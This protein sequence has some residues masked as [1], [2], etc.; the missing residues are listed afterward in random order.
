MKPLAKLLVLVVCGATAS[1]QMKIGIS[2]PMPTSAAV[3]LQQFLG[4]SAGAP[5]LAMHPGLQTVLGLDVSNPAHLQVLGPLSA[6]LPHDFTARAAADAGAAR[7]MFS[8]AYSMSGNDAVGEIDAR[9]G[10]AVKSAATDANAWRDLGSAASDL[11][12]YSLYGTAALERVTLFAQKVAAV[13]SQELA[14]DLFEELLAGVLRGPEAGGGIPAGAVDENSF[15]RRNARLRHPPP[16]AQPARQTAQALPAPALSGR[17]AE[18]APRLDGPSMKGTNYNGWLEP[19]AEFTKSVRMTPD[20]LTVQMKD[21]GLQEYRL[22]PQ[23]NRWDKILEV[24]P[25]GVVWRKGKDRLAQAVGWKSQN[26][27]LAELADKQEL[28]DFDINSGARTYRWDQAAK[29]WYKVRSQRSGPGPAMPGPVSAVAFAA[30]ALDRT[31]PALPI[32]NARDARESARV[33]KSAELGII[34]ML[35]LLGLASVAGIATVWGFIPAVVVGAAMLGQRLK[36]LYDVLRSR[37]F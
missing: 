23:L 15:A 25:W 5:L 18:A 30:P 12:P 8:V 7:A 14:K 27:P 29:L 10:A 33:E 17:A 4:S 32:D 2:R 21:G 22:S 24:S 35:S 1:A 26:R 6:Y 19:A 13:R 3:G 28:H 9:A 34:L 36:E 37:S 31:A 11:A 20:G 16:S